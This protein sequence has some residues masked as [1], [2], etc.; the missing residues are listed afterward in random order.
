LLLVQQGAARFSWGAGNL[1]ADGE[2]RQRYLA[3]LRAA[4]A[5]DYGSLLAF[6]RS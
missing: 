1:L 3:A 6:V 2:V 4:D 5:R